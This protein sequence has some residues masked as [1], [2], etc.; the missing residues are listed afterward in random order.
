ME[1]I[2]HA[3]VKEIGNSDYIL[4]QSSKHTISKFYYHTQKYI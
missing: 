3:T 2:K 4:S 1:N